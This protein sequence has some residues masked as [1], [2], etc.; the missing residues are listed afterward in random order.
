M[1]VMIAD[2]TFMMHLARYIRPVIQELLGAD[3]SR[4]R[5]FS[6]YNSFL[7]WPP[8]RLSH[9]EGC[10]L[11]MHLF[12]YVSPTLLSIAAPCGNPGHGGKIMLISK[13]V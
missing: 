11:C 8:E 9:W 12:H 6:L 3:L 5:G 10:V 2:N 4:M 13:P 1:T 7:L